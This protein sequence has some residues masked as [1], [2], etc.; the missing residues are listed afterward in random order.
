MGIALVVSGVIGAI[1]N[2]LIVK[3]NRKFKAALIINNSLSLLSTVLVL[4]SLFTKKLILIILATILY[5]FFSVPLL[6][7][8]YE[9][10]CE[11]SFPIGEA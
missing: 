6:P 4:G 9:L 8:N 7:L 2:G 11:Q 5:G 10:C 1:I 3:K